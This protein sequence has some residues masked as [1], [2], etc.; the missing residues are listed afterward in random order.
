MYPKQI[1]PSGIPKNK[2]VAARNLDNAFKEH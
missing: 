2:S 1:S